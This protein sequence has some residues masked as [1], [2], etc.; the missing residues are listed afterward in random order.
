MEGAEIGGDGAG[1]RERGSVMGY[2]DFVGFGL[3]FEPGLGKWVVG[4]GVVH[5]LI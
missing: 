1:R 2:S 5:V 4:K 3:G